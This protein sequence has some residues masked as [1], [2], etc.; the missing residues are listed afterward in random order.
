MTD[1]NLKHVKL[2]IYCIQSH[3]VATIC[4]RYSFLWLEENEHC[5]A[6]FFFPDVLNM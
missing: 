3:D 2:L 6:P 5:S 4:K 1:L